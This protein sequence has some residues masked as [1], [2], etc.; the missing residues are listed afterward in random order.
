MKRILFKEEDLANLPLPPAGYVTIGVSND[1][2]LSTI[3]DSGTVS[4]IGGGLK[5]STLSSYDTII[6]GASDSTSSLFLGSNFS[7]ENLSQL[8]I[9]S[10]S[11]ISNNSVGYTGSNIGTFVNSNPGG[12]QAYNNISLMSNVEA[13][14]SIGN[15]NDSAYVRYYDNKIFEIYVY[16]VAPTGLGEWFSVNG[17]TFSEG[18]DFTITGDPLAD[19]FTFYTG[20]NWSVDP[21][22]ISISYDGS[23]TVR[24]EYSQPVKIEGFITNVSFNENLYYNNAVANSYGAFLYSN[25]SG[26]FINHFGDHTFSDD[27]AIKKGIEYSGDYSA[28]FATHSLV[29]KNYV[30]TSI[31]NIFVG[32]PTSSVGLTAGSIWNDGGTLKIVS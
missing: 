20:I 1:G 31:Q 19:A 30:D 13:Y 28:D 2:E 21:T 18:I 12:F 23:Y 25:Y 8:N 6:K 16:D 3:T 27:R 14:T 9:N 15:G 22:F 32:L 5:S 26:L 7:G 11:F 17:L 4:S 10:Q 29:D 24:L